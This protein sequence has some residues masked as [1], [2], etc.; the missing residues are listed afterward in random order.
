MESLQLLPFEFRRMADGSVLLVNECGDFI[1]IKDSDFKALCLKDFTKISYDILHSLESRHFVSFSA[2]LE[3]ALNLCANKYRSRREYLDSSTALHMLVVTL[4]CNHQ[5]EYCQVSSAEEDAYKYDMPVHVAKRIVEL[6]FQ[7]PSP[8]IKLEFQGGDA[9]LNW[10]TVMEAVRYAEK[11]NQIK[12]K[13]LDFVACTNLYALTD[14]HLKDIKEHHIMLSVSL[15][16]PKW[17]HDKHR[18]LRGEGTCSSYDTFVRNLERARKLLGED[19][20][21]ALMTTTSDSLENIESIVDEYVKLGFHGIFFRALN[22]Y[23]DAYRNNLYYSPEAFVEMY[24]RG[25][26][27]ILSLNKKGIRFREYYTELLVHRI[28]SPYPTG[29]VDLQSPSGAGVS[30]VIY[31]YTGDV[32]PAD[33]ARMLARMG[34]VTFKMGNVFENSYKEIFLSDVLRKILQGSCVETIPGCATCAYRTYC[35]VDVFRNYLE[36]GDISNVRSN[37]FFCQKQTLVFDYLFEKLKDPEFLAVMCQ[38]VGGR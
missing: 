13:K 28:L 11:I 10:T 29:F 34:N 14:E 6:A 35:G 22:P 37:G 36:T 25:L 32:Y 8:Y 23:G 21:S 17:L 19:C 12:K 38:W 26:E 31:D 3:S 5:C 24:K 1:R 2:N 30:G 33:E 16:G 9:L 7:S 4:R 18:C 27:Y 20:A 15:D